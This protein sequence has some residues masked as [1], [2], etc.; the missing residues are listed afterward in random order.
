[1][2][3]LMADSGRERD[4]F[5]FVE[6]AKGRVLLDV[7]RGG[8]PNL[9]KAMTSAQQEEEAR[10]EG[11]I[12]SLNSEVY[13]QRLRAQP[14]KTRLLELTARL[15]TARLDR[16]SFQASLYALHPEL[17][18]R[19][20]EAQPIK[21]DEAADLLPNSTTALL[22]YFVTVQRTYLFVLTKSA[23]EE[24]RQ[25]DLRAY[26]IDTP[27][28]LLKE[29]VTRFRQR[30]ANHD[31][32]VQPLSTEL[33]DLLVRQ[34]GRQLA[35]KTDVVV[36]ADD[37]LWELPFQA[38]Q[39]A[40]NHYLI[41]DF[42]ISYVPSLT[43]LRE[44]MKA[45]QRHGAP[46]RTLLAVGNPALGKQTVERVKSVLMDES[47]APLPEAERQVRVLGRLY[48]P[49]ASKTYVG[50]EAREEV[51][52]AEAGHF[53]ILHLATHG[54]LNDASPMYSHL[55]LS[56]AEANTTE[57]GLLEAWEIMNLDLTADLAVLSACETARGRVGPGEGMI[58][59]TWALFIAGCPTTVVS[60]W[61]VESTSTTELM[62]QFHKN[63]KA[64]LENPKSEGSKAEALRQAEL[65]LLHSKSYHHPFFW[66]AFVM[67]GNGT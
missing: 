28:E 26:A 59:L 7:L 27:R 40:P 20:G 18:L 48:S 66:A 57:D 34:A 14:D 25:V 13:R 22:E 42:A 16:E 12:A 15:E 3:A 31:L 36:V 45:R 63:L 49:A 52:K 53:R 19:R 37:I 29:K 24:G 1:M 4:A 2:V 21:V 43:V 55:V 39:S 23:G 62:V 17:R 10:L 6:R 56:Q 58:G 60:Q 51:I 46:A 9:S 65:R 38:L 33:Y 30:L 11:Q 44:M 54:V 8:K 67:V 41:E 32:D 64:L 50:A 61:K 47:L 35:G 5:Q